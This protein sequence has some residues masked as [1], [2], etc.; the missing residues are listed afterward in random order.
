MNRPQFSF[1]GLAER[2]REEG[3]FPDGAAGDLEIVN[4]VEHAAVSWLL[5]KSGSPYNSNYQVCS[6]P[7]KRYVLNEVKS[8]V[9]LGSTRR[10]IHRKVGGGWTATVS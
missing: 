8:Q 9:G 7:Q 2:L 10:P 6:F 3:L 1:L 5:H 4:K